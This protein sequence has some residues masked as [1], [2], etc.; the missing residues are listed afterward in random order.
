MK[1]THSA[2]LLASLMLTACDRSQPHAAQ[3]PLPSVQVQVAH[4]TRGPI[5][6]YI[7]LPATIRPYQQVTLHA[8]V[9]GYLKTI[10]V[11]RGD[12]VK[13]GDL[14]AELEAPELLADQ[15]RLQA[16]VDVAKT[17]LQRLD[18][19]QKKAPD[20]IVP[21]TVDL[22]RSKYE[23]AAANLKRNETLLRYC[24]IVAPFS[25]TITR[26]WADP[27]ALI[28]AATSGAPQNA[29]LLTLMDNSRLRIEVAIPQAEALYVKKDLPV[30]LKL[31]EFVGKKFSGK[32]TRFADALDD[33]SKTMATEVE[34][35]NATHELRP[36]MFLTA[37]VG[38]DHKSDTLL[39]PVEALLVEKVKT[40]VF[41]F[42]DG[43]ARKSPVKT[44]F[45]DGV[46]VEILEGA[47]SDDAII[48]VGK[49]A[50]AD[51][52]PVT[53]KEAK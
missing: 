39:I 6:R 2:I 27:G 9:A 44:G 17:D 28:P 49:L 15:S 23:V 38:I 40:S 46:S 11:D 22:A 4:P 20:L 18:D 26:R 29:A 36:G 5:T 30:E 51:G 21:L 32:I 25:G 45:E 35:E 37:K 16:E 3:A 53:G 31:D 34:L 43:K 10:S 52:Q 12:Q 7:T 42:V 47:G 1:S 19:A 14:L 41:K 48:L 13:E 50:L 24:R 8:K 33:M